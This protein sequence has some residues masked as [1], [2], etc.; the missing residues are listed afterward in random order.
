MLLGGPPP[1]GNNKDVPLSAKLEVLILWGTACM[2][3]ESS[4]F[5][6]GNVLTT[7]RRYSSAVSGGPGAPKHYFPPMICWNVKTGPTAMEHSSNL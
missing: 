4:L 2:Q 7:A 3:E 1:C 6:P 5:L